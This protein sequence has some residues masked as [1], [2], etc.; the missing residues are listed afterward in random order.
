MLTK[1]HVWLEIEHSHYEDGKP[2]MFDMETL[3]HPFGFTRMSGEEI[4]LRQL[5]STKTEEQ[6]Q[7]ASKPEIHKNI[8][9]WCIERKIMFRYDYLRDTYTFDLI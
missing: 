2:I 6:L 9:T 8:E 4:M 1:H 7:T 3:I 5:I